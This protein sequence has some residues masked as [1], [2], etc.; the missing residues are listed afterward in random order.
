ML[1]VLLDEVLVL[2]IVE[3]LL[4]DDPTLSKKLLLEFRLALPLEPLTKSL[5]LKVE[6]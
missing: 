1:L 5:K 4:V 6:L 3:E 2:P